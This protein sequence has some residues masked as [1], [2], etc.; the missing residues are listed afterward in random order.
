MVREKTAQEAETVM[1][2]L[3]VSGPAWVG[4]LLAAGAAICL[5]LFFRTDPSQGGPALL[6]LGLLLLVLVPSS[7]LCLLMA[8]S[9]FLKSRQ[10]PCPR[11]T[12]AMITTMLLNTLGESVG[13]LLV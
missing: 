2:L 9:R 1:K 12:S 4:A 10:A 8:A 3:H 7:L 6:W 5:V 11:S 13:S